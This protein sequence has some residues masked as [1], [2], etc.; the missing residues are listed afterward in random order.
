[1]APWLI[2]NIMEVQECITPRDF[3]SSF[4][5]K[6]GKDGTGGEHVEELDKIW[7][8]DE[9]TKNVRVHR[10]RLLSAW[11]AAAQAI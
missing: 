2:K 6:N 3:A 1:M 10:G 5:E 4:T 11:K 8:Q 7:K 9:D